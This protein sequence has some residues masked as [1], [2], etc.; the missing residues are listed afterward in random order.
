M[1][2]T[3]QKLGRVSFLRTQQ[4]AMRCIKSNNELTLKKLKEFANIKF[5]NIYFQHVHLSPLRKT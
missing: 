2:K 1:D 5:S 4:D 3:L